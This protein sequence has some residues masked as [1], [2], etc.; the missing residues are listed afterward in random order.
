MK[1]ISI[2]DLYYS[3]IHFGHLKK[4]ASPKMTEYIYKTE[5]KISIINLDYTLLAIKNCLNF[6]ENI[7]NNN[8]TIL[9]VGTKKQAS[10]LIKEYGEKMQMPYVNFRWLGGSLTNYTTIKKSIIKLLDL[11]ENL[12]RNNLNYL[13]KKELLKENKKLK[14]LKMN[15]DGI[16]YMEKL[17]N[18]IFVIDINH[19][20][21]AILEAKK[22]NI[23]II[24]I[25]DTN[26][27]P[28][29]ID[30]IIPGNDDS[31]DSIKFYLE[32]IYN[33]VIILKNKNKD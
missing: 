28:K 7:I 31:M 20:L 2:K 9:L 13:T 29:Y 11:E 22:L 1:E 4:F 30:Y 33:H 18:A 21:T 14:K 15:F 24:G 16:K 23:P 32:T 17:P 26:C 25:V 8:G 3:K 27:N 5:N 12:K 19:E 10:D 6:L